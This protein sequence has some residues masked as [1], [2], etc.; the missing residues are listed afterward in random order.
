MSSIRTPPIPETCQ[1]Y[2]LNAHLRFSSAL[3][4][5][6]QINFA[7]WF[8]SGIRVATFS[9]LATIFEPECLV[10]TELQNENLR[11]IWHVERGLQ[12]DVQSFLN[13]MKSI[14]FN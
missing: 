9:A 7:E 4:I 1:S 5:T 12:N 2:R 11:N 8:R 3:F 6:L 13:E 14:E 10:S